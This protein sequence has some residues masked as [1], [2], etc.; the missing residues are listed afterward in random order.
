MLS[1]IVD[2]SNSSFLQKMPK[3]VDAGDERPDRV[4]DHEWDDAVRVGVGHKAEGA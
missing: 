2:N 4:G 1:I 3:D